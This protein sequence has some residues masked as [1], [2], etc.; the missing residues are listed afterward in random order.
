MKSGDFVRVTH[1]CVPKGLVPDKLVALHYEY[2][3]EGGTK[4]YAVELTESELESIT[5]IRIMSDNRK[6]KVIKNYF[7]MPTIDSHRIY[8]L[9]PKTTQ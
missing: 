6:L 4:W 7:E 2:K 8:M 5:E 9:K 1:Q 3:T